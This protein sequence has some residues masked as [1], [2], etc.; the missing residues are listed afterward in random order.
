MKGIKYYLAIFSIGLLSVACEETDYMTYDTSHNGLYFNTD[1]VTYSFGVTPIEVRTHQ[2]KI[3]VSV[4]GGVSRTEARKIGYE[5]VRYSELGND[6]VG[7]IEGVHFNIV[8]DVVMP[9]SI[10][11]Y[12]VVEVYR[13][14][15]LGD[16]ADGFERYRLGLNLVKNEYFTPTLT[17]EQQTLVLT[18]DNAVERPEWYDARGEKVFPEYLYGKW[19]PYKLIKMVEYYHTI[20]EI[21]PETYKKMIAQY[22]ENLENVQFGDPYEYTTVFRKYVLKPTY[23]FFND[24][25][26]EK[27]ILDEYPDFIFDFPDPY[28]S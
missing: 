26:N 20:K 13:D 3:P 12:I 25:A 19:H 18:F 27:M 14:E 16:Y 21:L 2:V 7:A 11:G 4:M 15:L 1:S 22:G 5:F 9:D 24:P 6:T 17:K 10:T 28:A 23:D 8:S